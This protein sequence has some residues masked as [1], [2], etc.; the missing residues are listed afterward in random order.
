MLSGLYK[1][2]NVNLHDFRRPIGKLTNVNG[3]EGGEF[4]KDESGSKLFRG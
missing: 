1:S 2:S 3:V 4:L